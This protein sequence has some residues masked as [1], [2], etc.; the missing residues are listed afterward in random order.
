[1]TELDGDEITGWAFDPNLGSAA[2][3]VQISIDGVIQGPVT[4]D[5]TVDAL[6]ATVGSTDHGF[7][8]EMPEL[9][10]G[11]HVVKVLAM[12]NK[13]G[14]STQIGQG[15][16][17]QMDTLDPTGAIESAETDAHTITGWGA[18]FRYAE[19]VDQGAAVC[20][21][22]ALRTTTTANVNRPDLV[23]FAGDRPITDTASN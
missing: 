3:T 2:A 23:D 14:K 16:V 17:V 5:E 13:S 11:K 9:G 6:Q 21:R 22:K 18:G 4:A 20:G 7:T 10:Y 1:M 15:T 8:F 19:H 12:D